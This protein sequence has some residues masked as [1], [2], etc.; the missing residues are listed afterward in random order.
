MIYFTFNISNPFT[1]YKEQE[2]A[3]SLIKDNNPFSNITLYKN[4]GNLLSLTFAITLKS[5]CVE[6]GFLGY[7]LVLDKS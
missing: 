4:N 7:S 5:G 3:W 1:E 2:V 6:I